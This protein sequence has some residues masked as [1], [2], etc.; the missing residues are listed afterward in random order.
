M[1]YARIEDNKVME[2]ID[3]GDQDINEMFTAELVATMV[4]DPSNAAAF[5]FDWDGSNFSAP[6]A[7]VYTNDQ[8]RILR[9]RKLVSSD[10]TQNIDAKLSEEKKTE[11]AVYR[12]ALRDIPAGYPD[13]L[14]AAGNAEDDTDIIWP[15]A[16]PPGK[17]LWD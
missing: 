1:R 12:Q 6:A 8:V 3:A 4:Q 17:D 11:W 2:V 9:N 5:G 15:T 13:C 14:N 10:W 16:P 7:I